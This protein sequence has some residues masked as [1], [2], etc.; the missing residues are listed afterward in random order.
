[1]QRDG[2][3]SY[4]VEGNDCFLSLSSLSLSSVPFAFIFILFYVFFDFSGEIV[5][6]FFWRGK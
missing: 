6:F 5:V 3:R 2:N 4:I 1:M